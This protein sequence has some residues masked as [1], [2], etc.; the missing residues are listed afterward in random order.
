[1]TAAGVSE[2]LVRVGERYRLAFPEGEAALDADWLID[3]AD[4]P[5]RNFD[6]G[7]GASRVA[8]ARNRIAR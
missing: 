8:R 7:V 5:S 2:K 1:M 6:S 3:R 4:A